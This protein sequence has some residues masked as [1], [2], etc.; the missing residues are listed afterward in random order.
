MVRKADMRPFL[1]ILLAFFPFGFGA[2]HAQEAEV[3]SESSYD[4]EGVRAAP[5]DAFPVLNHPEMSS[6][7]DA[8]LALDLDEPII[9]LYLGGEARAYPISVMGGIELVND[10][11]GEIPVAVSW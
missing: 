6:V 2:L 11:C 8:A 9:G 10:T 1:P 3:F 4:Q 5:R 7:A